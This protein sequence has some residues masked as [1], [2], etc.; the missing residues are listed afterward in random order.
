MAQQSIV[1]C[2]V[3]PQG[4]S[5]FHYNDGILMFKGKLYVGTVTDLASKQH[6]QESNIGG[7]SC[8]EGT[9]QKIHNIFHLSKLRFQVN[10]W[11]RSVTSAKS[12][13]MNMSGNLVFCSHYLF[14]IKLVHI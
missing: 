1:E 14:L 4:L 7:H 3:N 6:I 12:A 11:I 8:I 2:T 13:N 5:F 10:E 9:Y